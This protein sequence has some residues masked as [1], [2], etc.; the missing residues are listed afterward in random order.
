M[1]EDKCIE[2]DTDLKKIKFPKGG[3]EVIGMKCLNPNCSL[4][5]V[6]TEVFTYDIGRWPIS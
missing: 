5:Y 3:K 1:E 6:L 2:C 4:C